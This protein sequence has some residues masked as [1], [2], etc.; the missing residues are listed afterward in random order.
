ME[1]A[2]RSHEQEVAELRK[3]LEDVNRQLQV[4]IE[5]S[6]GKEESKG[7]A[8]LLRQLSGQ[9]EKVMEAERQCHAAN[10]VLKGLQEELAA[11]KADYLTSQA[12]FCQALPTRLTFRQSL[13]S[14][15]FES[16]Q[17]PSP[18]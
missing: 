14:D 15:I 3:H 8:R 2:R 4:A 12:R 6:C 13:L 18:A 9:R 11:L 17:T 7:S 16:W 5:T 10:T 1:E